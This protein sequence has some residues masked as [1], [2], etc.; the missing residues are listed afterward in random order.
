MQANM[1]LCE[2]RPALFHFKRLHSILVL[3]VS[4]QECQQCAELRHP[5]VVQFLGVNY[6]QTWLS[7]THPGDGE[8][9]REFMERLQKIPMSIKLSILP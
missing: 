6:W 9:G 7:Y 5:N 3:G 2:P 4:P 1:L 8:D